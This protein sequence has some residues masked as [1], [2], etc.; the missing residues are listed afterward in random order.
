MKA[1]RT[2]PGSGTATGFATAVAQIRD[3]AGAVVGAGFLVAADLLVTCAHVMEDGGYGPGAEVGL[4]F[5]RAPGTPRTTGF[6]LDR[7]WRDPQEQDIALVRLSHPLPDIDPLPLGSAAG[8]GGHRVLSFGFPQQAPRGGHFGFAKAGGLLPAGD[9]VGD[10]LQLTGANDLTTGF[11]G[12]PVLDETTGLVVGMLTAITAPDGHDR[13][14]GIAYATP[15]AVLRE[16]W[17]ALDEHDVSPYRALEPFTAEHA[18]WFKGRKEAVRQVLE[19]LA[20]GRRV[21][22]LLGPSGSGKSSLVQA[23]VL[24][25]LAQGRLPGSDRW[26]PVVVRPGPDLPTALAQAG[27]LGAAGESAGADTSGVAGAAPGRR[28][29]LIVDQF[30]ELL[31]PSA[32]PQ[33]LEVIARIT[34]AI[35]SDAPLCVVLVMRDDFYSRLSALAPDLLD[36][37]Q[38]TGGVLNIPSALTAAELDA[39]VTGPAHDLDTHFEAGLAE[40]IIADVLELNPS[41]GGTGGAPVTVLP[42]LEVALTRLWERR[43]EYDGRLTHD[44]YRRIGAVTGALTDWCDT[45]LSELDQNQRNIARRILTALV[46]PADASLN[47]PAARQQ[48]PL[49]ELRE[50]AADDDPDAARAVDEVLALLSRH[51]IVTTDRIHE[52]AQPDGS[53]GTAVAELVH[54]ALIRDWTTLREWVEQDLRFHGW[55][56]RAR[57]QHARWND[58][59]DP[60]DLPTGTLLA[61]GTDWSTRRRLPTGIAD[62]LTAGRHRQQ[63]ATRRSRRLN[64]VLATALALAL[65]ASGL[66]FWQRQ[67]ATTEQERADKERQTA[68]T[69]RKTA[70]SRQ[71]AAQSASLI[72]TNP[73]VASLLAVAAYRVSPTTEATVSLNTAAALPLR[74]LLVGHT[75]FVHSV[76]FSPDGRTLA[77][78]SG[79]RT[80]RLWDPVT[81]STKATLTDENKS[82]P[83]EDTYDLTS[84]AFSPDGRTLATA[85]RDGTIR[86]RDSTTAIAQATITI[87]SHCTYSVVFSPD[88]RTVAAADNGGTAVRLWDATTGSAQA[89]FTT[90]S[91]KV[92]SGS[93]DMCSVAFS[94]DGHTLATGVKD[95]HVLLWDRTTGTVRTTLTGH[96]AAVNSLVFSPDGRTLATASKDGT[97]RLWDAATGAIRSTLAGHGDAVNSVAFSPD[98]RTLATASND[99][100]V[101]LWDRATGSTRTT[102]PGH[103]GYVY[104]VA[105]SPDGHTLASGS[106]DKTVRLW[107]T[108]IAATGTSP[109][110]GDPIGEAGHVYFE[111]FSPDGVALVTVSAGYAVR[112]WDAATGALRTTLSS[113][114][115]PVYAVA[116][117]PDGGTLAVSS[118]DHAVRLWDTAAGTLRTTLTLASEHNVNGEAESVAFS[119]DGHTLAT[120]ERGGSVRLWDSATGAIRN[121]LTVTDDW[122]DSVKPVVFSPDGRTLATTLSTYGQGEV[123]LWDTATAT[124]R[125]TLKG[126]TQPLIKAIF[127]PDGRTLAT[128]SEDYTVRLWDTA[129]GRTQTTISM[130][131]DT[132]RAILFSPDGHTLTTASH[133]GLV[134][135]WDTTTGS[136]RATTTF[137]VPYGGADLLLKALSP[138][139]HTLATPNA[140]G[141]VRFWFYSD[142]ETE[143]DMICKAAGI[144]FSPEERSTYLGGERDIPG[145]TP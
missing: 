113:N 108:A 36:T 69:E 92:T 13:G 106:M 6:V 56:H 141:T 15:T 3:G 89:V 28:E 125:A 134:N 40:Q 124:V 44:A 120:G 132:A 17:P 20:G 87:G 72:G 59:N 84:V 19:G 80:V 138:N 144:T 63:A 25:A 110:R 51:R 118:G 99:G 91:G 142:P 70:L 127:S 11:S 26:R 74:H 46:R 101:R 112:L 119:P 75:R 55:L 5:P 116:F 128:A 105:F 34:A 22:V 30:E 85:S 83:D 60:Q 90:G 33:A 77:S 115:I 109:I 54:D 122:R 21:V 27:L 67:A 136:R 61:E 9:S 24:P 93:S 100:T 104:S 135:L 88:G 81:G 58:G 62:F 35:R 86:L 107:D 95:G 38:R 130:S 133:L 41:T 53:E 45:A 131:E 140:D 94:P 64:Q 31:A 16:V 68:V 29:V 47:I 78:A 42:L 143:I 145:C 4:V 37:A 111:E 97:A 2:D 43:L 10:L 96:T 23:G 18:R 103:F 57:A 126:H 65:I 117:S 50:L 8:C 14:L 66:A 137:P 39:I 49:A 1:E 139:G 123:Q 102:L 7:A 98:G 121:T 12:G 79:D 114:S 73:D 71:F 32:G 129:T 82:K 48:L 52:N 76:A